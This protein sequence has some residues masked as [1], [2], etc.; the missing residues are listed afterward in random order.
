MFKDNGR[1]KPKENKETS[2]TKGKFFTCP[3]CGVKHL[4]DSPEFGTV[5]YC[6][7]C[8]DTPLIED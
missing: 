8:K 7:K 4:I 5:Y 2:N 6:E 1:Y 3:K